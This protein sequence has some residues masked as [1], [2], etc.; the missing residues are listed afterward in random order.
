MTIS[1]AIRAGVLALWLLVS[2]TAAYAQLPAAEQLSAEDQ[3]SFREE[4][5]HMKALLG[6]A[7]DPGTVE[8]QIART[9]AAGGQWRE[10]MDWLRKVVDA[11][12]GFDPSRDK[13]F[14]QLRPAKEFH[15]LLERV[16]AATP[17]VTNSRLIRTVSEPDL[18]PENLAYDPV[19]KDFFL[20]STLKDKILRCGLAGGA[21]RP[22]VAPHRAGLGDVLG[23]KIDGHSRTLWVTSNT[24]RGASLRCYKLASGELLRTYALTGA[25]LFNDLAVGASGQVFVTDTKEGS[26]Y[27]LASENSRL[28]KLAPGHIFQA[29]NGI[30]LSAEGHRLFVAS[31]GDGVT[32]IDLS[33]HKVIPL[34]HPAAICLGYIDGLYAIKGSLLAIQNGPMVPRIVR[35]G[36][37]SD[38]GEIVSMAVLERRNP[39]FDGITTGVLADSRFYYVANSQ[40]DRVVNGKI[41]PGVTLEPLR[42]LAIDLA[43]R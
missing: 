31:F 36:L 15:L 5:D 19:T 33:S 34:R 1:T 3:K 13:L 39:L 16:R 43:P 29:A 27:R 26:L 8:F 6:S 7:N 23:L 9:Y 41:K 4:L 40:L 42:I 28:E 22:F 14:D 11:N 18:F 20:G 2:V 12:L 32:A 38:E 30:A 17:P 25:H 35:F 10:A 24:E 37:S 21:C